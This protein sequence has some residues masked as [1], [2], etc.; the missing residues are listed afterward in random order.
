MEL[1]RKLTDNNPTYEKERSNRKEKNSHL[2]TTIKNDFFF[3]FF[4]FPL[5]YTL[6]MI[7]TMLVTQTIQHKSWIPV[8]SCLV[9]LLN[10]EHNWKVESLGTTD[11]TI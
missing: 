1:H 8:N 5:I 7:I 6:P 3:F 9:Y 10:S 4:F 2:I 11:R